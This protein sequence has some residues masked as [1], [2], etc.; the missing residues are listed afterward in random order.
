[1]VI[2]ST[3]NYDLHKKQIYHYAVKKYGV[4]RAK[5]FIDYYSKSYDKFGRS[6][7]NYKLALS[8][9]DDRGYCKRVGTRWFAFV[10][11][12]GTGKSTLAKNVNYFLDNSFDHS[13]MDTEMEGLIGI[14]Q[15]LPFGERKACMLDEPD[16]SIAAHSKQ[17]KVLRKIFGKVRQQKI[18]ISI[19]ATDLKDIPPYIF[20]KLDG[21]FF[22]NFLGHGMFIK[23]NPKRMKYL[24]QE[25]RMNY[26]KFGYK[27]FYRFRGNDGCLEFDTIKA[28][29]LD[30]SNSK[31]LFDKKQDYITDLDNFVKG[32]V[33]GSMSDRDRIILNM[34]KD[35]KSNMSI[36]SVVGISNVMVGNIIKKWS[37]NDEN[38]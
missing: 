15:K 30:S 27:I 33:L 13:R 34:K 6:F 32:N 5:T 35:G 36:A 21:V 31:Y 23:N 2:Q 20:R 17:G 28:T 19:C 22:T 16:D 10:G 14:I 38:L 4:A 25:L 9:M 11:I 18:F 37:Y 7:I 3:I 8:L 24:L 12:G 1:M 29:P 26:D